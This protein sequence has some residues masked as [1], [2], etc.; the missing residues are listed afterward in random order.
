MISWHRDL[1]NARTGGEVVRTTQ[2]FLKTFPAD[3]LARLPEAACP[4]LV[5]DED[6]IRD[7]SRRLADEYWRQR[8]LGGELAAT[9]EMWSFFLR[10]SVQLARI[11]AAHRERAFGSRL[12][13]AA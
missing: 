3:E 1:E 9:R 13:A 11:D 2:D 10:A 8:A 12:G 4:R 7:W 5:R 6:D